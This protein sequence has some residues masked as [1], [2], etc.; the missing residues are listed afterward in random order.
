[1]RSDIPNEII[2]L[3]RLGRKLW[4]HE[5]NSPK[6][7]ELAVLDYY[8]SKGWKG[9]FTEHYDYFLIIGFITGWGDWTNKRPKTATSLHLLL[10]NVGY[11]RTLGFIESTTKELLYDHIVN[12]KPYLKNYYQFRLQTH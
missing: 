1:M 6:R 12:A 10:K 2:C 9:Y 8:R 4:Q 7:V 11:A 5:D 3:K